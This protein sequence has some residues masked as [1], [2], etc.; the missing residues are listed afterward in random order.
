VC[1]RSRTA[2][3]LIQ[4]FGYDVRPL[5]PGYKELLEASFEKE[6]K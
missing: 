1:V 5:K 3:D 2:A 4:K 6:E